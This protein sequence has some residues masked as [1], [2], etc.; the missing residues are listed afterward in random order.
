MEDRKKRGESGIGSD[1]IT[2]EHSRS[3]EEP[4]PDSVSRTS[5][6]EQGNEEQ[7]TSLGENKMNLVQGC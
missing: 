7:S 1:C 5:F 2:L 3:G 4:R 6:L